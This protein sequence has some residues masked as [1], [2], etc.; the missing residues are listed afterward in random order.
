LTGEFLEVPFDL[1]VLSTPWCAGGRR[2][3]GQS[4]ADSRGSLRVLPRSPCQAPTAGFCHGRNFSLRNRTLPGHGERSAG[5]GVWSRIQGCYRVVQRQA[6]RQRPH[7]SGHGSCD[8]CALCIDVC[9]YRAIKLEE[10][11][12]DGRRAKRIITDEILCKGCGVCA[13]TCPKGGVEVNGF[14]LQQLKAQVDAAL[15]AV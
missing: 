3:P 4:H 8:G 10:Y 2:C 5:T 1:L 15:E 9:P 14:T 6:Y 12:K 7:L 11:E 13:A